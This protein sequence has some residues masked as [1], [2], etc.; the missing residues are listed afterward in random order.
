[1]SPFSTL[2]STIHEHLE[3]PCATT[4]HPVSSALSSMHLPQPNHYHW[5]LVCISMNGRQTQILVSLQSAHTNAVLIGSSPSGTMVAVQS[6]HSLVS[7]LQQPS[8]LLSCLD[9]AYDL[10]V[11]MQDT[12]NLYGHRRTSHFPGP[13]SLRENKSGTERRE[14]RTNAKEPLVS[15][16]GKRKRNSKFK[17]KRH[18]S[19]HT[20]HFV[21][22]RETSSVLNNLQWD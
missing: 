2:I 19:S 15:S 17:K 12:R 5:T 4:H 21:A 18:C 7:L 3:A 14:A 9:A 16:Q 11:R 6:T 1:M 13:V 8:T 22:D 10:H 20:H